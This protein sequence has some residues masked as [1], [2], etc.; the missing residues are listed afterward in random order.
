M[1]LCMLSRPRP[2]QTSR[3]KNSRSISS[4]LNEEIIFKTLRVSNHSN[5]S[6]VVIKVMIIMSVIIIAQQ[7]LIFISLHLNL[8]LLF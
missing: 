8:L 2:M 7:S 4:K 6:F 3:P 1:G 5:I